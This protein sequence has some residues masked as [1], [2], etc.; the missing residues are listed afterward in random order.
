MK[1]IPMKANPQKNDGA[2]CVDIA[3]N[4]PPTI[5]INH[6]KNANHTGGVP[7]FTVARH[8]L[9]TWTPFVSSVSQKPQWITSF[10]LFSILKNPI[11]FDS[12]RPVLN[13]SDLRL[14][15]VKCSKKKRHLS[16]DFLANSR[17][18]MD[19]NLSGFYSLPSFPTIKDRGLLTLIKPSACATP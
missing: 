18:F 2:E 9:Q 7:Y 6:T 3:I 15:F 1:P 17:F 13:W 11:K 16:K 4:T 14:F 10:A 8:V 5:P 19:L 12:Y